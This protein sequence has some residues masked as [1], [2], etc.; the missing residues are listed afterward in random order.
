MNCPLNHFHSCFTCCQ[1]FPLVDDFRTT[2]FNTPIDILVMENDLVPDGDQLTLDST[3]S[4]IVSDPDYG[5]AGANSDGTVTYTP[6][7]GF[8]GTDT[9]EYRVCNSANTQCVIATVTIL[10]ESDNAAPVASKFELLT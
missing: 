4:P 9:F 3:D 6:I 8:A 1:I 5:S 2:P 7:N 10:V